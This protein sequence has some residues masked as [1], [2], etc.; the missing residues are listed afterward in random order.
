MAK[1]TP[2]KQENWVKC[3]PFEILVFLFRYSDWVEGEDST[4]H[5]HKNINM[6]SY[7]RMGLKK[8]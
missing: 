3:I 8:N 7:I 1:Y 5:R 2:N 6:Y 4:G